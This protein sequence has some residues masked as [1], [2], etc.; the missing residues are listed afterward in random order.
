[1]S[2]CVIFTLVIVSS[3]VTL[4]KNTNYGVSMK[5]FLIVFG[6]AILFVVGTASAMR[7][8]D[9]KGVKK[10]DVGKPTNVNED[11]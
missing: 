2:S 11:S 9:G 8:F 3:N 6:L 5:L 1:M 10:K 7:Y 4:Y